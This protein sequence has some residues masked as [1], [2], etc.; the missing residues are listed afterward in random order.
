[1][2]RRQAKPRSRNLSG[3]SA[4]SSQEVSVQQTM[5]G[6]DTFWK[7]FGLDEAGN[8][9]IRN[10]EAGD[11]RSLWT[12]GSLIA[13]GVGESEHGAGALYSLSD[14]KKVVDQDAVADA[15]GNPA[16]AGMIL[17]FNGSKWY[18]KTESGGGGGDAVSWGAEGVGY[19]P[20]SVNGVAKN[21]SLNTHKHTWSDITNGKPTTLSEYGI[22]DCKIDGG[23]ITIGNSSITPV[24]SLADYYPKTDT[25]SKVEVNSLISSIS[26]FV[27]ESVAVLPAASASTMNKIFLVPSASAASQNVK[28]EYITID[29]GASSQTRYTWERI[30]NTEI[31]L[32]NYYTKAQTDS[33]IA[34]HHDSSKQ[35]VIDINHKL[36][37]S[38][39]S[40]LSAVATSG[41]Y[42]DLSGKP[43]NL[44]DFTDDVVSGH[45][46]PLSGGV[47]SG[48]TDIPLILRNTSANHIGIYYRNEA[49]NAYM[50][51][52]EY[53]DTYYGMRLM[54]CDAS[55]NLKGMLGVDNAGIPYCIIDTSHEKYELLHKA[56]IN[57]MI[58]HIKAVGDVEA[59]DSLRNLYAT[60]HDDYKGRITYYGFIGLNGAKAGADGFDAINNSNA[61]LS[62]LTYCDS[63]YDGVHQIGFSGNGNIYHRYD[64]GPQSSIFTNVGW[65]KIWDSANSNNINVEWACSNLNV[66]D[67]LYLSKGKSIYLDATSGKETSITK[68]TDGMLYIENKENDIYFIPKTGGSLW[69]QG[70]FHTSGYGYFDSEAWFRDGLYPQLDNKAIGSAGHPWGSITVRRWYPNPA[71]TSI[72]VEYDS[73]IGALKIS[74]NLVVTGAVVV[75]QTN[76]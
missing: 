60:G 57:D 58:T 20:L 68:G 8:L 4:P 21:L 47:I 48:N 36:L 67:N 31:D 66:G 27:Y 49:D 37:A 70:S 42:S 45:Y 11:A 7:Y 25:Y 75:G 73:S 18:A 54:C 10:T 28:D 74:G 30:G 50:A 34:N 13:G 16:V 38:Y 14:I 24:T 76:S 23:V 17:A 12:Y 33:A 51:A 63:S 46:L 40:G 44:S 69:M 56:N 5:P 72:Y 39:I 29:N 61:M 1:M 62:L 55:G 64:L 35:N 41:A 3:A 59:S 71:D 26:Q 52:V 6:E 15:S 22:T 65:S 43:S 2:I 32:S 9:F 19:V 53:S